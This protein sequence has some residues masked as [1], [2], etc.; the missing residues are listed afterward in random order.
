MEMQSVLFSNL[1]AS[2]YAAEL[3]NRAKRVPS[4]AC[5]CAHAHALIGDSVGK[6]AVKMY[7]LSPSYCCCNRGE[8]PWQALGIAGRRWAVI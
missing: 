3:S 2:S 4:G 6:L 5:I 1:S 8:I 7:A